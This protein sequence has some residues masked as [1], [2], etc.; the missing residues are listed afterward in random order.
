M[1]DVRGLFEKT[2]DTQEGFRAD[3]P[4]CQRD[5][6]FRLY[7]NDTKNLGCCFTAGCMWEGSRGGV[8][9][10][11]LKAWVR[12]EGIQYFSHSRVVEVEKPKD[13]KI[14][15]PKEYKLL[16]ELEQEDRDGVYAYLLGRGIMRRTL[17][18]MKVGYCST[19]KFW[20]Y[21]IFPVLDADGN[22]IYWQGRRYKQRTP[23]FYNPK[24]SNKKDI[25]YQIGGNSGTRKLIIVE[26]IMNA[27]TLA[28]AETPTR[29]AVI[30]LL[31]H[32]L[33]EVQREH[34]LCYERNLQEVIIALD[35]DAQ[36]DAPEMASSI[37]GLNFN[38]KIA[39]IPTGE[40]LNSLG[41]MKSWELLGSAT[42]YRKDE[43]VKSR[44]NLSMK[45]G[46]E[47]DGYRLR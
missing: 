35:P 18:D 46:F 13:D 36:K 15:L 12:K 43:H 37:S 44:A 23:K 33:S 6:K 10:Y 42:L 9:L 5:G 45:G 39:E 40:D 27:L 41:R 3:C 17:R 32:S 25:F 26:S 30:A 29:W 2:L 1:E 19:G 22:V 34:I 14:L 24:A 31:G 21:I 7:W 28:G 11:R 20:G 47:Y 16:D 38:V 8:S 4:R